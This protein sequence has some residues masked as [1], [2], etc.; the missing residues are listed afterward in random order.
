MRPTPP[1]VHTGV[2][3][4]ISCVFMRCALSAG[5]A[6]HGDVLG[7]AQ[8]IQPWLVDVRRGLHQCPELLY[9]LTNTSALVRKHLDELGLKYE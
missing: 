6:V 3:V 2:V 7:A 1:A 5:A 8:A 9:D 4:V